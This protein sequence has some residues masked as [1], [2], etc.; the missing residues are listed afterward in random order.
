VVGWVT[1]SEQWVPVR[2]V[3]S[4]EMRVW[5]NENPAMVGE[6]DLRE[7]GKKGFTMKRFSAERTENWELRIQN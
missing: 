3:F 4:F 5:H 7:R 6:P 1:L 2:G